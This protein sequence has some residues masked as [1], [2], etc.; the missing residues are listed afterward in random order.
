M[1]DPTTRI[2]LERKIDNEDN[3][4]KNAKRKGPTKQLQQQQQARLGICQAHTRLLTTSP[5]QEEGGARARRRSGLGTDDDFNQKVG[6]SLKTVNL[7]PVFIH[8]VT[9]AKKEETR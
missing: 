2:V 1:S 9:T 4:N 6:P 7:P 8:H 3:T 5:E